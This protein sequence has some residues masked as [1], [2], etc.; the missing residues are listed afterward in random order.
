MER[1]KLPNRKNTIHLKQHALS[2][3][4][5]F[6]ALSFRDCEK[7]NIP[8]EESRVS[9][10]CRER[11]LQVVENPN[12]NNDLVILH[13]AGKWQFQEKKP[14]QAMQTLTSYFQQ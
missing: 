11:S 9:Q 14:S 13:L 3:P 4:M 2:L 10:R 5:H 1:H 7:S 8:I 12:T 6:S